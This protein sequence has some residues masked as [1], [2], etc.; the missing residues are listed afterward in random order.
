MSKQEESDILIVW[1]Y[2]IWGLTWTKL[3]SPFKTK[4]K[5]SIPTIRWWFAK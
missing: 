5:F 2:W 1:V 3:R 4:V